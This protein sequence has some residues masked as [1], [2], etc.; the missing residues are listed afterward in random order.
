M[1]LS[2]AQ[3]I[4]FTAKRKVN[5]CATYTTKS[6]RLQ[7]L[8]KI[9]HH[10]VVSLGGRPASQDEE[11]SVNDS[12]SLPLSAKNTLYSRWPAQVLNLARQLGVDL[13]AVRR[14]HVCELYSS[15]LEK[16]AEEVRF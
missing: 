2:V 14:H 4:L 9:I 3:C 12:L 6:F 1:L 10:A 5:D 7:F 13:D 8:C 11:A 15:G 16:L